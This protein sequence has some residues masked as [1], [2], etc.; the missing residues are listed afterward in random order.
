MSLRTFL[1]ALLFNAVA[2]AN[3]SVHADNPAGTEDPAKVRAQMAKE[4]YQRYEREF[5]PGI[6]SYYYTSLWS[7]RW[8]DADLAQTSKPAE[9]RQLVLEHVN[10]VQ[11]IARTIHARVTAQRAFQPQFL[12]VEFCL[13]TARQRLALEGQGDAEQAATTRLATAILIYNYYADVLQPTQGTLSEA[14][15]WLP[16]LLD[17]ALA[18][19][20]SKEDRL[21]ALDAQLERIDALAKKFNELFKNDGAMERD[22]D[23]LIWERLQAEF[24]KADLHKDVKARATA[25]NARLALA[26]R[27]YRRVKEEFDAA[28]GEPDAPFH[29]SRRWHTAALALATNKEERIVACEAHRARVINAGKQVKQRFDAGRLSEWYSWAVDYYTAEAELLLAAEK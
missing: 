6:A 13:A 25:G 26:Q 1:L 16:H 10:R 9:R 22:L 4:I 20:K 8:L 24:L 7:E 28:R 21:A 29:A 11:A 2:W 15:R 18:R 12:G 14:V 5:G 3:F 19:A 23:P 17:A 27:E